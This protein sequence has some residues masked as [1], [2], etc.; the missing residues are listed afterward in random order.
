MKKT[1]LFGY[2]RKFKDALKKI[3]SLK[4]EIVN[5]QSEMKL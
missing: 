1:P 5:K 4:S 2:E 3:S